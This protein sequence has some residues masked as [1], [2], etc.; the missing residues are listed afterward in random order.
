ML[1][2]IKKHTIGITIGLIGS[3]IFSRIIDPNWD[4]SI[5]FLGNLLAS[6]SKSYVDFLYSDVGN[7]IREVFSYYPYALTYGAF[8]IFTLLVAILS[9]R[10]VYKSFLKKPEPKSEQK[11][12]NIAE[13][14]DKKEKKIK[15]KEQ[16]KIRRI[17]SKKIK[18]YY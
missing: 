18:D 17:I 6:F 8:I 16:K 13:E 10:T 14:L 11:L 3:L 9:L 7:G 15:K 4:N 12:E 5:Y 1:K 2:N